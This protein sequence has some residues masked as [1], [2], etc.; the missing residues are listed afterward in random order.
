M[1]KST[2]S[3]INAAF[4][5]ELSAAPVPPGLRALSV[6]AAVS[7]PPRG[8][9]QPR[10]LGLVAAILT[11][12]IVATLVV[13]AHA[14]RSTAPVPTRPS[15][16]LVPPSPRYSASMVYDQATLELVLFGGADRTGVLNETWTW[17][18][19]NW[20]LHHPRI[21]PRAG[22]QSVMAYDL[23]NHDVVLLGGA[24]RTGSLNETWTWDGSSWKQQH[25]HHQPVLMFG[26]SPTMAFDPVSNSV[27]LFG[28]NQAIS[29]NVTTM[30]AETWS[31]NG[32][33][34][35]QLSPSTSPPS[36]GQ[37]VGGGGHLYMAGASGPI[38]AG[39]K[40]SGMWEW[41]GFNWIFASVGNAGNVLAGSTAF[42]PH[43]GTIVTFNR[44]TWTWDGST[45]VRQH[46]QIHPPATGYMAYFPPLREIVMW[47]D[48]S[49]IAHN[50]MWAW[51]GTNWRLLQAGNVVPSPT[52]GHRDSASPA[53]AAALIRQTVKSS[54]PVLLATWLPDGLDATVDATADYF[55]VIYQTDQRDKQIEFGIVVPNPPPGGA[56][57]Q[58]TTVKFRNSIALKYQPAGYA[59][60]FVYDTTDLQSQRYLIW[61]E[62]GTMANP[63]AAGFGGPGVPYFLAATG[64]TDQEF[65]RIA[66]S[67]Q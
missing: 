27:L 39:H 49:G 48:A 51:D 42:D 35:R 62:P 4:D 63:Q 3:R 8:S 46:P 6:R 15:P 43:R 65:W 7:S 36:P 60:Y 25:P 37:L 29:G 57:S 59:E 9:N 19:K 1:N 32:S 20:R 45:L 22:T 26:W 56:N 47:G 50:D 17:D 2:R 64:Y 14:L 67:L 31:W 18:G 58:G 53:E 54:S 55:T 38:V 52:P 10:M 44:D 40:A 28:F 33:D 13:G 61:I 30:Q 21:V 24:D 34:W 5:E 23:A 66:N 12:A 41:D 16:S 11:L